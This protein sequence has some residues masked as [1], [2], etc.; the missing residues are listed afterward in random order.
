MAFTSNGSLGSLIIFPWISA[1]GDLSGRGL[2]HALH[3]VCV[4][5]TCCLSS[6]KFVVVVYTFSDQ[7]MDLTRDPPPS[8]T[9]LQSSDRQISMPFVLYSHWWNWVI[10]VKWCPF[11]IEKKSC[12]VLRLVQYSCLGHPG[13]ITFSHFMSLHANYPRTLF[14]SL[15]MSSSKTDSRMNKNFFLRSQIWIWPMITIVVLST[16]SWH[17]LIN[18]GMVKPF[19]FQISIFNSTN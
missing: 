10:S 14:L 19:F 5:Q 2:T 8:C 12:V 4:Y 16:N 3:G 15:I 7:L 6:A 17:K 1:L 13:F 9:S 18:F 11:Y